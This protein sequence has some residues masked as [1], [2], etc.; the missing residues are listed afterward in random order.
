MTMPGNI[1]MVS[2]SARIRFLRGNCNRASAYAQ[3]DPMTREAAVAEEA[4]IALLRSERLNRTRWKILLYCSRV[5]GFGR[6]LIGTVKMSASVL[7]DVMSVH[8]NGKTQKRT[9]RAI[10]Q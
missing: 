1:A 3:T 8:R 7:S 5:V 4:T 6:Y 9:K 2:T 10:R